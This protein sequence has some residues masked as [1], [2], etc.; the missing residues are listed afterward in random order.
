MS[1]KCHVVLY[2]KSTEVWSNLT[3]NS[4][5][6]PCHLSRFYLFSICPNMSWIQEVGVIERPRHDR[7]NDP[8]AFIE[9]GVIFNQTAIKKTGE[10]PFNIFYRDGMISFYIVNLLF[11]I[12]NDSLKSYIPYPG[13]LG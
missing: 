12:E 11:G 8:L 3:P 6:I 1:W 10:T 9:F 5:T 13:E 7:E 2:H 4:M